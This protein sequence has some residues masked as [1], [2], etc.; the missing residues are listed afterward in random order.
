MPKIT[1]NDLISES[2]HK[3]V[4]RACT[5][6]TVII[7]VKLYNVKIDNIKFQDIEF[8]GQLVDTGF[9]IILIYYVYSL[10]VNWST[11]FVSF[12]YW[13]KDNDIVSVLDQNRKPNKEWISGSINLLN[14][15]IELDKKNKFPNN[16]ND[17]DESVKKEYNNLKL[18]VELWIARLSSTKNSFRIVSGFGKF[19][20]VIHCLLIPLILLLFA[21]YQV[22]LA[23]N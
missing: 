22:V 19:Y 6:A 16:F 14:K 9:I 21:L 20:V 3:V 13:F 23:F 15:L 18:N 8:P 4:I 7:L 12:R 11:D 10:I 1:G 5:I 2:T 17:L